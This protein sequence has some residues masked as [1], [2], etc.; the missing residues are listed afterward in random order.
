MADLNALIAR[1]YQFQPPPDPFAQYAK[2]QQ[3]EQG[4]QANQLNQMKMQEYQ[5][6][7]EE[8]NA[9]R[10]LDPTSATYLQ[11]ITRINPEKGFAFAK[12]QQEAGTARTEGQIKSTKLIADK[13]ALLPEAYRMADTPEAYLQLHQSVHADPVLGPYLQSVGATQDKGR[14]AIQNAVQT[15]KFD[16]LRMG[17]MQSV[18][19]IL[20]S[21]KPLVVGAS[22]SVYNPKTGTYTQAPSAP[23]APTDVKK[24][25]MERDA[26]PPGSPNRALYDQQ[27]KD[28]GATAQTAR[29]RLA[30][31]RQKFDW[32]KSNP[33]FDL[34]QN[35]D[36][37]YFAVDKKTRAM[38]P[39]M[40]GGAAPAAAASMGGGQGARGTIGVTDGGRAAAAA[41]VPFVGKT[42]G[43]NEAQGNATAFG[44][45]M[46]EA[47]AALTALE[48]KGE[49]GTGVIGGTAS[50]LVGLVPFV[51]DK[52]SAGVDNIFNVLPGVLGGFS[53]EQQQVLNGRINFITAILRKESGAAIS[54]QEFTTAEKLYFPKPGDDATVIKQKQRARELSIKAMKVQAGPGAKSID[55]LDVGGAGTPSAN[56]P[57]G[58][59]K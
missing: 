23:V 24:L 35:A 51:G 53:P 46:K 29:D 40:V 55:Q 12:L 3:L 19:Q 17:S 15:G 57:L 42:S 14:A 44:M 56:D 33:G 7:M 2:Q 54:P 25:I 49:T 37:E 45:R 16:E 11:D 4:E 59:R 10:R 30:F 8:T 50:G 13:L 1:G 36:G 18:N 5:R 28:L 32:E 43:L 31:D 48:N 47:N 9:M 39:L 6:G 22:S 34:I 21:M 27:I 20:E 58:L 26:L 38:T 52:L 41:G